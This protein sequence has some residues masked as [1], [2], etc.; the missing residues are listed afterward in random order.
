[1]GCKNRAAVACGSLLATNTE[2]H[3]L[4]PLQKMTAFQNKFLLTVLATCVIMQVQ[5]TDILERMKI[6]EK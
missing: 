2:K 4:I 6:H 3:F 5:P 1:M